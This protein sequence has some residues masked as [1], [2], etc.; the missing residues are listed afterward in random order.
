[1]KKLLLLLMAFLIFAPPLA[2][3]QDEHTVTWNKSSGNFTNGSYGVTGGFNNSMNSNIGF[4]NEGGFVC[5][6]SSNNNGYGGFMAIDFK[7]STTAPN[8]VALQ[9]MRLRVKIS[10]K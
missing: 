8:V 1:M 7:Q 6:L 4:H 3:A 5:S 9:G 2:K 10:F